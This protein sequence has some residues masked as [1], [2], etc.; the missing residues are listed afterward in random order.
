MDVNIEA[1]RELEAKGS[2]PGRTAAD[3]RHPPHITHIPDAWLTR[4]RQSAAGRPPPA[5]FVLLAL[6]AAT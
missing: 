5:W 1:F 6:S 2:L 3:T 4:T